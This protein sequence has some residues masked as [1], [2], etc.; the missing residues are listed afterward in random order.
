MAIGLDGHSKTVGSGFSPFTLSHT[1]GGAQR[2]LVVLFTGM[3]NTLDSWTVSGLTYNGVGLTSRAADEHAG[4]NR[5]VR[6][7]VWT[8]TNP[9]AGSAYSVS[10]NTSVAMT[11]YGLAVFCLTG[12][13]QT[14]PTG[15][16]GTS[17][18]NLSSYS[19]SLTTGAADSWLMGGAG[20]RNGTL[21]WSPGTG[22]T[23]IF[24]WASG[25]STTSDI[26]QFGGYR[27][28]GAAGSYAFAATATGTNRGVLAA[29]EVRAGTPP[30]PSAWFGADL[31]LSDGV[32]A[33]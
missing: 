9:P 11:A 23:E 5:N 17:A 16:S 21:T 20:T 4:N 29:V 10:V 13:D 15:T 33:F 7:E 2:L 6:T 18:G 31:I 1:C 19:A 24:D 25:S 14:T 22:V 28:C 8:L 27:V 26:A 12:V 30:A 32:R 3:S